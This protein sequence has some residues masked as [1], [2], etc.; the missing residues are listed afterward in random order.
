MRRGKASEN[1]I[2]LAAFGAMPKAQLDQF[3]HALF[4]QVVVVVILCGAGGLL[5]KESIQ[6]LERKATRFGQERKQRRLSNKT[7]SSV[8]NVESPHCPACNSLMVKRTAKRGANAG[9]EFWGCS[10]YP[11]CRGTRPL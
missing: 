9:S 3:V 6:W 5:L 4:S 8:L 1:G 10:K 2:D 7:A 11:A